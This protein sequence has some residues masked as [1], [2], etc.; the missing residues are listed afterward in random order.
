MTKKVCVIGAGL[1]GSA[2]AA[3]LGKLYD[4]TVM[5]I[6][7]I[8][9]NTLKE[10]SGV[11]IVEAD[12]SDKK[13]LYETIEDASLVVG[14]VPGKFG[15]QLLRNVIEAGKDMIDI[16]FCPEDYLE[17]DSLARENNVTVIP[18]IGV[19]PGL[20]NI[21]CGY[22][23]Q[24]MEIKKYKCMV[25]GLPVVRKWPLEY[26]ASWSPAD[27]IEEYTRPAR[28][29]ENGK[30]V[31]KQALSDPE[32]I[33]FEGIGSLE[34]WNSDG[35]R[36]LIS[37]MPHIPDMVEK[38]LRYPGTTEYLKVLKEL[39]YFS[40][41]LMEVHGQMIRPVDLSARLLLPLW[42]M[43]NGESEFTVMRIIINGIEDGQEKTLVYDLYDEYDEITGT[44][45]MA[46]TTGYT[47]AA[48]AGLIL[49][50]HY[51]RKGVC[52]PEYLGEED[53]CMSFI[54]NYLSERNIRIE[55][56]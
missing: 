1:V 33:D 44:S 50:N 11:K 49:E 40:S 56:L 4:V 15:F 31:V 21:I 9:L 39:G 52:P 34:A 46:R 29:V 54:L 8:R 35:L 22:H 43:K 32:L 41:E 20:C 17:L 37:T 36:S 6:N 12:I 24:R 13:I 42:E 26:K 55:N 16:S 7:P 5:D 51:S 30:M 10:R 14:A 27:V 38:T 25:G 45:S 28:L 47:C 53:A 3:D 18:D 48:A 2:I 19:A 23:N